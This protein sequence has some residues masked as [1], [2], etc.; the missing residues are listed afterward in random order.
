MERT[1]GQIEGLNQS[2]EKQA[3]YVGFVHKSEDEKLREDVFRSAMEKLHLFT[4]ML[5]REKI[6]NKAKIIKP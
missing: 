5:H 4:Q 2:G 1:K 6:L 3:A